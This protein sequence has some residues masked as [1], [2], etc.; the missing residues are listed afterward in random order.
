MATLT[1]WPNALAKVAICSCCSV[2]FLV[3]DVLFEYLFAK[4]RN[5]F[6]CSFFYEGIL[7]KG[8]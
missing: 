8:A 6:Y 1:G 3:V 7:D 5:V 4:V 2:Y